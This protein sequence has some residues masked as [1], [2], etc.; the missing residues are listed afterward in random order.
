MKRPILLSAL[1]ALLVFCYCFWGLAP[2]PK[3]A[4]QPLP[5]P[6]SE[7]K[8]DTTVVLAS[9]SNATHAVALPEIKPLL[10]DTRRRMMDSRDLMKTVAEIRLHGTQDEKDWALSITMACGQVRSTAVPPGGG[11][12]ASEPAATFP[13]TSRDVARERKLAYESIMERC[14]GIYALSSFERR[15]L[16]SELVAGSASN[17]SELAK[18]HSLA[19]TDEDR[20]SDEQ[21]K[22]VSRSLYG[23]DPVLQ[24]EAFFAA[25][26]AIDVNAPGGA[27]RSEAF[28]RAFQ[29]ELV[30][31]PLSD[32]ELQ[33]ACVTINRCPSSVADLS[34]QNSPDKS[35]DRL[36]DEYRVALRAHRDVKSILAIR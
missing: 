16:Q 31:G 12:A 5:T 21:A 1:I 4:V 18:L 7:R 27:D 14:K 30:S 20:W 10:T 8:P 2:E 6:V 19:T 13:V 22:L 24:R 29:T 28:E 15:S 26:R 35:V 32:L 34:G 3:P 25:Q 36:T 23:G 33:T 9:A 17:S 11:V